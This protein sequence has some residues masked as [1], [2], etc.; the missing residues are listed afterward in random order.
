M[1]NI[2]IPTDFSDLSLVAI[3]YGVKMANRMNGTVTLIHVMDR[4]VKPTRASMQEE[5]KAIGREASAL[6]RERFVPIVEEAER[7]NKTDHP[8]VVK[9]RRGRSFS[10]TVRLFAKR[11]KIGLIIMGTKGAR[12][13]SKY[14]LG[15]N[16]VSVMEA[17]RIPVLAVPARAQFKNFK[18]IVYA[19]DLKFL[20]NEVDAMKPY[21]KLL[22]AT[23]HML[24]VCDKKTDCEQLQTDVKGILK[25]VDYRKSTVMIKP[26]KPVDRAIDA[27]VKELKAD[28][29][30][31]FTHK[32][33]AYENLFHR[34][35]T[36]KMAFQSHVPLLAFKNK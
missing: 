16:T 19:A 26:G 23:L 32:R 36:K 33:T 22:D 35:M 6:A 34:S 14:V 1:M 4:V 31:M 18:N 10:N 11:N 24:H 21:L 27:Y 29:V 30:T 28:M 7:F 13:L 25:Q 5:A 8:I 2:L 3:E 20:E 12:G 9:I 15:S 17:S